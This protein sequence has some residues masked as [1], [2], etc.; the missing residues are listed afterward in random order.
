MKKTISTGTSVIDRMA[1]AAIEKV[2][3]NASGPKSR[4]FLRLEREDRGERYGDDEQA[5]EQ[6]R[7]D[8]P[9]PASMRIIPPARDPGAARSRCLWAF[10]IMTTAPSIIAP[11]AIAIPPR[12]MMLAPRPSQTHRAERHQD[13]D[14]EHQDSHK[15]AAHVQQKD[16]ADERDDRRFPRKACA[17]G[18]RSPTRSRRDRS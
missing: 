15:R 11:M 7:P 2:L 9:R 14:R 8:L 13:P 17:S 10:S 12:L 4:P 16:D 1:A 3:V 18:S 5:E 6:R